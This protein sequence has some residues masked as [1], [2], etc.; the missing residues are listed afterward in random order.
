MYSYE[1]GSYSQLKLGYSVQYRYTILN[2]ST[3][4]RPN[5]ADQRLVKFRNVLE[6]RNAIFSEESVFFPRMLFTM[7]TICMS[8]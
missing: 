3:H 2:S 6:F 7:T 8:G 4:K 1:P 5:Q